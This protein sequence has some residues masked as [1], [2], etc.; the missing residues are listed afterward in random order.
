MKAI[1]NIWMA[2]I[3]FLG[4]RVMEILGLTDIYF[5]ALWVSGSMFLWAVAITLVDISSKIDFTCKTIISGARWFAT[6]EEKK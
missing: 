3:L 2:A 4:L 1:V 5:V 6:T